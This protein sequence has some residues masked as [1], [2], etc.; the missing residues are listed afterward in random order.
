MSAQRILS[1]SVIAV[2]AGIIVLNAFAHG[3][4]DHGAPAAATP[5]GPSTGLIHMPKES[6]FALGILT[7]VAT[8]RKLV[9][10]RRVAGVIIPAANARAE[11]YPAQAG[12]VIASRAWKIGDRVQRGQIL[13][14]IEQTLTGTERIELERDLI[15][16]EGELDEATRDYNRKRSL[17]G[18]VAKKEIEFARI[19]LASA[20]ERHAALQRV[21]TQGTRPVPVRAPITGTI[22]S[23]DVV[24]GEY[25][26][27]SKRLMEIVNVSTVWVEAQVYERDLQGM[28]K[29]TGAIVTSPT[30]PGTYT[31]TLIA[32]G[33]VVDPEARTVSIIFSV[34]NPHEALK[35]NASATVEIGMGT[36]ITSLSIPKTAVIDAAS[37]QYV[38]VHRSPEEFDPVPVV[39]G[40]A[41]NAGYVQVV[42]GIAIRDRVVVTGLTHFRP[43]L[44]Q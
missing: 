21:L 41:T 25:V 14:S 17:E 12:R 6:Q 29:Q 15:E 38:I 26:E 16:A 36:D 33:D 19:R 35:I 34:P 4:E 7:E 30:S 20:R 37:G 10:T 2:A 13:F 1:I 32:Q 23:A 40:S 18:V 8:E 27:I 3:G 44:P 24:S 28:P 5:A 31:G 39:L 9:H 22:T 43:N 42:N 11:V